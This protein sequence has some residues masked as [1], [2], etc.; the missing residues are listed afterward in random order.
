G[1]TETTIGTVAHKI[2]LS[3]LDLYKQHPVIGSPVSNN[4]VFILDNNGNMTIPG[5]PGEICIA[6]KGLAAGYLNREELT[7]EKFREHPGLQKKLYYTG[8]LGCWLSNGTILYLGRKDDQVK[9]RGYRVEPGEV[10]LAVSQYPGVDQAVIMVK[11]ADPYNKEL[12]AYITSKDKLDMEDLRAFLKDSVPD[13]MIPAHLLQLEEIPLTANHKIDYKALPDPATLKSPVVRTL[14]PPRTPREQSIL[15]IWKDI[16]GRED[17][18]IDDN[19]FDVGGHSLKAIQMVN[20]LHKELKLKSSLK[21]IFNHPTIRQLSDIT[22]GSAEH[23]F[24][25]I[26]KVPEQEYYELSHS[27]KRIWLTSQRRSSRN[28][29]NVPQQCLFKGALDADFLENAFIRLIERHEALRTVFRNVQ[30]NA[31]QKILSPAE[32]KF[33]LER[34]SFNSKEELEQMINREATEPF[35]IEN[36]ISLRAKLVRTGDDEHLLLFTLHHIISDGW[37]RTVMYKELL[38]FY[39]SSYHGTEVSLPP[40]RIQYKDYVGWH[41]QVYKEQE[42]YWAETFRGG[43]PVNNF[44]L[45]YR[46]PKTLT[47]NGNVRFLRIGGEDL[48]KLQKAVN[49][50]KLTMNSLFL[51]AYG[52]LLGE[53]CGQ[54]QV[55]AGTIVSGRSHLDLEA[56]IGVFI[57]YLPIR[58]DID[59]E[60]SFIEYG[61]ELN[62]KLIAI[63]Q[64][65]EYPFDLM[66]EKFYEVTDP[67]RNPVFDT[68]LIFHSDEDSHYSKTLP[69]GVQIEEYREHITQNVSKLDF[70]ADVITRSDEVVV[71]LEYNRNLFGEDTMQLFLDR[72]GRLL[73]EIAANPAVR[74]AEL[75][76]VPAEEIRL[77][78]DKR[79]NQVQA[80]L[81]GLKIISSFTAEPL[82]D[83]LNWWVEEIDLPYEVSF[84]GYHQVLQ[85]LMSITEEEDRTCVLLNRFEDYVRPEDDRLFETLDLVFDKLV[86]NVTRTAGSRPV[87]VVLLPVDEHHLSNSQAAAYIAH[88]NDQTYKALEPVKNVYLVDL[89]NGEESGPATNIFD[90]VS[91]KNAHI[92]FTEDFFYVLAYRITRVLWAL[93]GTPCKVIA[94]DCDN[95][96]WEGICGEDSLADIKVREGHRELQ[97]YFIRKYNEGFL[98]VILSKNNENDVWNVF[99][100]H[101]DMLLKKEHFVSWK[102]DWQAKAENIRSLAREL[103]LGLDSFAFIDDNPLE[104]HQMMRENPQVLSLELPADHRHYGS[105]LGHVIAFD[106][107][108]ISREDALRNEMYKA[109]KKRGET[110]E[111]TDLDSF[112]QSLGLEMSIRRVKEQELERASQLSKRTNQFNLNGMRHSVQ[113]IAAL[114][115]KQDFECYVVHVRDRFGDYG[116]VGMVITETRKEDLL[117]HSFMLSCRVLGRGVEQAVMAVVKRFCEERN[118][119]TVS[120]LYAETAK[121]IPFRDFLA[122]NNWKAAEAGDAVYQV[123]AEDIA[124]APEYIALFVDGD[125]PLKESPAAQAEV[126]AEFMFDHIG[127]AVRNMTATASFFEELG[128]SWAPAVHDPLQNSRLSMGTHPEYFNVELVEG[129]GEDSPLTNILNAGEAVPYHICFRVKSHRKA[130]DF[131]GSSGLP[132]EMISEPRPAILFNNLKVL[133]FYQKD[134]GLVELIEDPGMNALKSFGSGRLPILQV[135]GHDLESTIR[136]YQLFGFAAAGARF[137][138]TRLL[139]SEH[140]GSIEVL[141]PSSEGLPEGFEAKGRTGAYR[142]VLNNQPSGSNGREVDYILYERP[143]AAD[144]R[145]VWI[146]HKNLCNEENLVHDKVYKA[147]EFCSLQ[148]LE[149]IRQQG[150]S[151]RVSKAVYEPAADEQEALLVSIFEEVLRMDKVGVNDDF[152]DLGGHSIKATQILSRIYKAWKVEIPLTTFFDRS[153]VRLV[154]EYITKQKETDQWLETSLADDDDR[155]DEIVL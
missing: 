34:L 115:Q 46:R 19:F 47:F 61:E 87:I 58:I 137:A 73:C 86:E 1:P 124:A 140:S 93:R 16:L 68:M 106:K 122:G 56:M 38:H 127:I 29:Y 119:D 131:L 84:G 138:G 30:G 117:L 32:V 70:K 104:C 49:D 102:I 98:L 69:G 42:G 8:D 130:L 39:E 120:A 103:S 37:S 40:L 94:L 92:P 12:V 82:Q 111:G 134:I 3:Q 121:N 101:P 95:T 22:A 116:L 99:D 60:R 14:T 48:Q 125:L 57:N 44:P 66:V 83:Y 45:D 74:L 59:K 81:R 148:N 145:P 64:N 11:A 65:Q 53:Y 2:D 85:E 76:P 128:F 90:P 152:F 17:I 77:L 52:F 123:R 5:M 142:L 43:M 6:G 24:H 91:Y 155:F 100:N 50:H 149:R 13:Y 153:T 72:F 139:H 67:S 41:N 132:Y 114:V 118:I 147:L 20:R 144:T 10:K 18:G 88:L 89:R 62:N 63:Y 31:V 97:Q 15:R 110:R 26:E 105:F 71:R 80:K 4:Q 109:E 51:A 143:S 113:D 28:I 33:S 35:D 136:F 126:P 151:K 107:L 146:W 112:L 133:F 21:D 154:S 141:T 108:N 75:S 9:I 78:E 79:R 7:Q 23:E 150:V 96:L 25:Q 36:G 27:Q 55:T 135:L 129:V 54:N